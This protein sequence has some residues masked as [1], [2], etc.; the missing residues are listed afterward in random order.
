VTGS[1]LNNGRGPPKHFDEHRLSGTD[2]KSQANMDS[3]QPM[4]LRQNKQNIID[5]YKK[6]QASTSNIGR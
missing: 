5:T 4:Q 6:E 2:F 3:T 1:T